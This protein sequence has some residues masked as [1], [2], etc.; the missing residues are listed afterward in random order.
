M[1]ASAA[2]MASLAAAPAL[3]ANA[4]AGLQSYVPLAKTSLKSPE[5]EIRND[6][7]YKALSSIPGAT[8]TSL[9]GLTQFA[10]ATDHSYALDTVEAPGG[11]GVCAALREVK[12]AIVH[13]ILAIYIADHVHAGSC[14]YDVTMAHER[15]HV[16]YERGAL[17]KAL[18][19]IEKE[20]AKPVRWF[21]GDDEDEAIAAV[22]RR[23]ARW[24]NK[25]LKRATKVAKRG[26]SYL[27]I[28]SNI[29]GS[30]AKCPRWR[31]R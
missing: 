24:S 11:R 19:E 6:I 26:H 30:L 23:I 17:M 8:P 4:C 18:K 27:D 13:T 21:H 9:L 31:R 20:I 10:R 5:P 3:A 15:D 16:S 12:L 28:Q 29:R 22:E 25:L 2:A 1:A 14:T 7:P